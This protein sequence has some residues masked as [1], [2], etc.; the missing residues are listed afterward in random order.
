MDLCTWM[1]QEGHSVLSLANLAGV[2]WRTVRDA[3]LGQLRYVAKAKAIAGAV[4]LIG[5]EYIVSPASMMD[6]AP[7]ADRP[8]AAE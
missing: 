8:E 1:E 7:P 6:L 4:G 3:R 2:S 5:G